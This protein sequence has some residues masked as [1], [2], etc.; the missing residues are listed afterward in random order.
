MTR[1]AV[2]AVCACG[3][4]RLVDKRDL[5]RGKARVCKRC[6]LR[7]LWATRVLTRRDAMNGRWLAGP[8]RSA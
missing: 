5:K 3:A 4:R 6:A 8:A 2:E 1:Y 7:R